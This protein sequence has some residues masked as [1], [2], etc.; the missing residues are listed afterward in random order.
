MRLL[1]EVLDQSPVVFE[2]EGV[3]GF[4]ERLGLSVPALRKEVVGLLSLGDGLLLL[5]G[6]SA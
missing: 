4:A 5:L 6:E 2:T 3:F 1:F